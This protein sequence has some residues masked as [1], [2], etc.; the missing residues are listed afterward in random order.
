[1]NITDRN[2][3]IIKKRAMNPRKWT[4]KKLGERHSISRER[5]RQIFRKAQRR[6]RLWLGTYPRR[7]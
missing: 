3:D 4:Y 1:M 2:L 5:V 7:I 6:E